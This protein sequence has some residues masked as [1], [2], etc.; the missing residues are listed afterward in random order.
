M[1]RGILGVAADRQS[2]GDVAVDEAER[3]A[4]QVD[5]GGDDRR[6][7]PGVVEHQQLHQVIHVAAMV[8]GVDNPPASG[9]RPHRD[10]RVLVVPFELAQDRIE[11]ILQRAV[12]LVALGGPQLVEIPLDPRPGFV[13]AQAMAAVDVA[14]DFVAGEH[15]LRDLV[16]HGHDGLD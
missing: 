7:E 13:P 2:A 10:R 15:G 8:R 9:L 11:R 3:A 12:Q 4:E 1:V 16:G 5:A 6:L 14:R